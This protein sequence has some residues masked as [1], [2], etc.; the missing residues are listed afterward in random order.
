LE[1]VKINPFS[2]ENHS[3]MRLETGKQAEGRSPWQNRITIQP[4]RPIT[5]FRWFDAI[6]G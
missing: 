6:H 1:S 2:A 5:L 3:K 4:G